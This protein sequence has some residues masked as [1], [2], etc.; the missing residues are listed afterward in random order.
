MEE[1]SSSVRKTE[2]TGSSEMLISIYQTIRRH[3]PEHKTSNV[4]HFLC[5]CYRYITTSMIINLYQQQGFRNYSTW[6]WISS[7][8]HQAR[9]HHQL[10]SLNHLN[11]YNRQA[12]CTKPWTLLRQRRLT[13]LDKK[14]K[15]FGNSV[16]L[17]IS[18]L[19]MV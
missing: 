3:F 10:R 15:K 2:T 5:I 11:E 14:S 12:P 19:T 17:L 18:D 16:Q 4:T 6:T 8:M 1:H 7:G 9:H 13:E